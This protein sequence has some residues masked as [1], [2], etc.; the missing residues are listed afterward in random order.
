MTIAEALSKVEGYLADYL[1]ADD[2]DEL[3][4]I[5]T[6]L[7]RE[8]IRPRGHWTDGVCDKC[9]YDGGLDAISGEANFCSKC[10]AEMRGE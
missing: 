4:V 10:G 6:A 8:P 2:S 7:K 1:P 5:L 9:G 3:D